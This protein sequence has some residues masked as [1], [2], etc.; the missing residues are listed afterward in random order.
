M[1]ILYPWISNR[2]DRHLHGD[3][4]MGKWKMTL[5][6]LESVVEELIA[7]NKRLEK[8]VEMMAYDLELCKQLDKIQSSI[9]ITTKSRI[10]SHQNRLDSISEERK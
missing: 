5:K 6:N 8:K 9:N 10:D 1:A 2:R 4:A 7:K 3:C